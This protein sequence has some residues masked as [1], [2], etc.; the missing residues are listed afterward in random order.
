MY[1]IRG[2]KYIECI[3]IFI[4]WSFV[5]KKEKGAQQRAPWIRGV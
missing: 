2:L 3:K 4:D 1:K 5:T